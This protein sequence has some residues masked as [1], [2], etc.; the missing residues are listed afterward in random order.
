MEYA[1]D[2]V[3]ISS[4]SGLTTI[5]GTATHLYVDGVDMTTEIFVNDTLVYTNTIGGTTGTTFDY[6]FSQALSTG[7]K[8]S[9]V[10]LLTDPTNDSNNYANFTGTIV[11]ATPEP[12]SWVLVSLGGCLLAGARSRRFVR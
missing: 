11:T 1:A 9:F 5:S 8:V 2:R 12:G 7:D 3:W 10:T 4:Y 6:S